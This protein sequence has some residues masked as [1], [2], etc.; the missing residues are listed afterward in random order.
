ML[1]HGVGR[2]LVEQREGPVHG[3]HAPGERRRP[4]PP[5]GAALEE[6][7]RDQEG[8]RSVVALEEAAEE[9]LQAVDPEEHARVLEL[10]RP[11]RA[12]A[13]GG[14]LRQRQ[15]VC[16]REHA[17]E[18]DQPHRRQRAPHQRRP[19]GEHGY[20][21][22]HHC[23]VH[24]ELGVAGQPLDRAKERDRRRRLAAAAR[25]G[26]P[27]EQDRRQVRHREE[28]ERVV[29]PRQRQPVEEAAGRDQP[30][31]RGRREAQP[32]PAEVQDRQTEIGDDVGVAQDL[33]RRDLA[34]HQVHGRHR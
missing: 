31:R 10:L 30:A 21:R 33:E 9:A 25:E 1:L 23:G 16:A 24:G 34:E 17:A 4:R 7:E 12:R 29:V 15:E 14:G 20:E 26:V 3:E 5:V 32:G 6:P 22:E 18:R 13:L 28:L 11:L 8:D 2:D 27:G 19:G